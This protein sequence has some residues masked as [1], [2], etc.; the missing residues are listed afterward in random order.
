MK[1]VWTNGCFDLIHEGHIRLLNFARLQGERLVV[2]VNSDGMIKKMKG[3]NRP[4][5][6][7]SHRTLILENLKSVDEVILFH[8]QAMLEDIIKQYK[9]SCIVVG[10]DYKHREVVGSQHCEKVIFFERMS[11]I[12]TSNTIKKI[13]EGGSSVNFNA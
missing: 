3:N 11:D 5:Y 8:S 10:N 9:P 1:T 6:D 13:R 7:E 2:G 12:S 4:I